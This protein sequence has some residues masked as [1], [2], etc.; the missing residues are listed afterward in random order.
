MSIHAS[1]LPD[2]TDDRLR[3]PFDWTP[4]LS[5]RARGFAL[6]AALAE[7]GKSGVESLIDRTVSHARR[8]RDRLAAV[9]GVAILNEAELKQ[10][11]VRFTPASGDADEHTRRVV[12]AVQEEG[13]CYLT[14]TTWR[15]L[16]AMRISVSNATTDEEDVERSIDSIV[17]AHRA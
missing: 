6:Y 15:G 7:M 11:L 16:A 17:R 1:Y 14:G 5:R 4:E 3:N 10:V 9:P 2:T 12:R 13:T 8:F